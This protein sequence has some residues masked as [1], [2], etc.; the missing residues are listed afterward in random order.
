MFPYNTLIQ[1]VVPTFSV[2]R[3]IFNNPATIVFW[4]AGTKTVVKCSEDDT[5][6]PEMGFFHAYFEKHSGMTKTQIS[7]Y[8]KNLIR[9]EGEAP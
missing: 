8:L 3:V 9:V 4:S 1:I 7:K 2:A 6:S 5:F